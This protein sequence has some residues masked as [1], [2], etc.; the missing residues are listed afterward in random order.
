MNR[1]SKALA[2]AVLLLG[3]LHTAQAQSS[4]KLPPAVQEELAELFQ[5]CRE[6]G[7]KPHAQKSM[8]L[9]ADLNGDGIGD[10]VLDPD[11]LYCDGAASLFSGSGGRIITVFAGTPAGN[12]RVVF[13]H[14]AD[15]ILLE[16]KAVPPRLYLGVGGELCGQRVTSKTSRA[17]FQSCLRP[18]QWDRF[19]QTFDFAP[20]SQKRAMP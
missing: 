2:M 16:R 7:G 19:S 5:M 13:E 1:T 15:D 12:A 4:G 18:L 20:V 6:A 9:R 8:L 17:Q 3:M 10:Y 11:G 14:G